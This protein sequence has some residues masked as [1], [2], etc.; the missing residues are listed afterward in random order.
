MSGITKH[1]LGNQVFGGDI[2][3]SGDL[4]VSG[5]SAVSGKITR[6]DNSFFLPAGCCVTV[7]YDDG[8]IGELDQF[9]TYSATVDTVLHLGK[10][11]HDKLLGASVKVTAI[12]M[13]IE[14]SNVNSYVNGFTFG[15][16][17]LNPAEGIEADYYNTDQVGTEASGVETK[18]YDDVDVTLASDKEIYAIQLNLVVGGGE[19][20]VI[21]GFQITYDLV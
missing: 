12:K 16:V 18:N 17:E 8:V 19:N 3:V 21:R 11:L 15:H 5:N 2:T 20:I 7:G 14:N 1:H 4:A 13:W 10:A 6:A 9:A